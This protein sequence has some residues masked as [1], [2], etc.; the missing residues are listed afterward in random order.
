M[1]VVARERMRVESVRAYGFPE[2]GDSNDPGRIGAALAGHVRFAKGLTGAQ[3][4]S[5]NIIGDSQ[6][7]TVAATAGVPLTVSESAASMCA[8]LL[9]ATAADGVYCAGDAS[10]D[11]ELCDGPY[12]PGEPNAVRFFAGAA[13]IGREGL[14]LG[15]L[16]VWSMEPLSQLDAERAAQRLLPVRDSVV[17][18]LEARRL[19]LEAQAG[20]TGANEHDEI[21]EFV[22]A[23]QSGPID[24]VIDGAE[25]QTQFQPIVHI[26]TGSVVAFEALSRGPAGTE[27]ESPVA[28][29][30]AAR[31]AGRLGELDWLCRTRAMQAAASSALP[32]QLSWFINVEHAGLEIECP[33]HLLA[34]LDVARAGLRVVLEVVERNVEDH[35]TRLL[36]AADQA[37]RE[38]WGVALD[39][40][41]AGTGS[42]ALLPFLQPDV[43]KLDMSLLRSASPATAADVT[44]AVRTYAEH[45]GAVILAEGIETPAQ[46]ELALVFGATY[47]QGHLYGRPGP[48]PHDLPEP[49]NPIPLRQ[50]PAPLHDAT[51][52]ETLSATI[53]PQQARREHLR[54]IVIHL[55]RY[56]ARDDI[57]AVLLTVIADEDRDLDL[58]SLIG[59][60]A[61]HNALT[62][63]L[64]PGAEAHQQDPRYYLG[65]VP[66]GSR[67]HHESAMIV[68]TPHWAGAIVT[69]DTANV[70][71]DGTPLVDYVYTHDRPAVIRAARAYFG[72]LKPGSEN[73]PTLSAAVTDNGRTEQSRRRR[74]AGY[75]AQRVG[76][77]TP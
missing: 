47:G 16:C 21:A 56:C 41:G 49:A 5:V 31:E 8:R 26:A 71:A 76:S 39:D 48:L 46:E 15:M 6:Q 19:D 77:R 32:E 35:V 74:L 28:L 34:D 22:L 42:L 30:D 18:V 1:D 70:T 75:L 58:T 59:A 29:L 20:S 13:L 12:L 27:F 45:S 33:S 36:H 67:L 68:V 54:H 51:P 44:A 38:A 2:P 37:R 25:V 60:V 69:R 62:V 14:P 43:V 7:L 40:V 3:H 55:R 73:Y 50:R 52:F 11:P 53:T 9:V 61:K 64:V 10:E 72:Q 63:C 23:P 17:E 24:I 4:S 65:P 57:G 66:D